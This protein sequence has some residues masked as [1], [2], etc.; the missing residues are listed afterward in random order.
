MRPQYLLDTHCLGVHPDLSA[1]RMVRHRRIT[2]VLPAPAA[3]NC[4][5]TASKKS[6]VWNSSPITT[7]L[8]CLCSFWYNLGV[9]R[10]TEIPQTL[11]LLLQQT[12]YTDIRVCIPK[13]TQESCTHHSDRGQLHVPIPIVALS[14]RIPKPR[15]WI[16]M[17]ISDWVSFTVKAD[18]Q[19]MN[20][21]VKVGGKSKMKWQ[22]FGSLRLWA[23]SCWKKK[24]Y[25]F[26]DG[27]NKQKNQYTVP[28]CCT[29][30]DENN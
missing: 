1:D 16:S 6:S 18:P 29:Y 19:G 28:L 14:F 30:P 21:V 17:C 15:E 13:G 8:C 5:R 20:R 22:I 12:I 11:V 24:L 2:C 10:Q 25:S 7:D 3:G 4:V 26:W 27:K 23:Y 9:N